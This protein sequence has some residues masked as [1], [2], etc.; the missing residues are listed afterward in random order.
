MDVRIHRS[1]NRHLLSRIGAQVTL[2]CCSFLVMTAGCAKEYRISQEEFLEMQK[3]Y[4]VAPQAEE[5]SPETMQAVRNIMHKSFG[6]YRV[7]PG[8]VLLVTMT[9]MDQ[10]LL[11]PVQVRVDRDG[12]V[13]LP[14]I[15]DLDV[16][17]MPLEDVEKAIEDRYVPDVFRELAVHVEIVE[18]EATE[19]LVSGAASVPGLVKLR[20]TERNLLFALV[21]AGGISQY[22]SGQVTLK[23]VQSSLEPVTVDLMTPD[24]L[25]EAMALPPLEDGDIITVHAANPNTLFVGGLVRAPRPQEYPAGV[26]MTVLQALAASGGLRTDVTPREATLIRRMPDGNEVHVK[27]NLDRVTRGKDP[28]LKLAAGDVL[29]VPETA[30]TRIQDW[31]NKNIF[32]RAGFSATANVNYNAS[33]LEYLNSNAERASSNFRGGNSLQDLFDPYGFLLRNQSL[34]FLTP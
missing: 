3:A 18:A 1:G 7:G 4:Q 17:N 2:I 27:L 11:P 34:N 16:A 13:D 5:K 30:E 10:A 26:E 31:I 25:L 8:D 32:F 28:N 20:R 23:R 14:T 33:A 15:G 19:V 6:P 24:G 21:S 29:W 22:A 9:G 12:K